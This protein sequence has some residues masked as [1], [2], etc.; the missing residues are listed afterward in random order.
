MVI[1]L[2][3]SIRVR[4]DRNFT[5]GSYEFE[6]FAFPR[7]QSSRNETMNERKAESSEKTL[8]EVIEAI[9][10]TKE[11]LKRTELL[12]D[13]SPEFLKFYPTKIPSQT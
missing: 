5:E 11:G 6:I 7:N 8:A 1:G 12:L 4:R 13:E 2:L 9:R 10:A 3:R